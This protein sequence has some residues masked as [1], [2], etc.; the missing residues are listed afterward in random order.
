MPAKFIHILVPA[1]YLYNVLYW[2]L[3]S[4]GFCPR[5]SVFMIWFD[6][7]QCIVPGFAVV[8]NL[9][10]SCGIHFGSQHRELCCH[11]Q[12]VFFYFQDGIATYEREL[13]ELVSRFADHLKGKVRN[14]FSFDRWG[15][16]GMKT[17][18]M[19]SLVV[20]SQLSSSLVTAVSNLY[21]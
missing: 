10:A 7:C 19:H 6:H 14:S 2:T 4:D 18:H 16:R 9:F 15:L 13:D 1:N 8:R 5:A 3:D 17:C 20:I 11:G 12:D 21:Y